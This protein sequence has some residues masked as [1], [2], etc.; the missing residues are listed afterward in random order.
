MTGRCS[1][2]S[3]GSCGRRWTP[4]PSGKPASATPV[5]S[6]ASPTSTIGAACGAGAGAVVERQRDMQIEFTEPQT[7]T[8]TIASIIKDYRL[9][10]PFCCWVL[11]GWLKQACKL[12][13]LEIGPAH[14]Q[15][16]GWPVKPGTT[17][18]R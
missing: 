2:P 3:C 7:R 13:K 1:A 8:G 12:E 15:P 16:Y 17:G 14:Y 10:E 9:H 18:R 4:I 5:S 6:V 11:L